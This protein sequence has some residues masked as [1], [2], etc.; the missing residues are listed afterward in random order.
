MSPRENIVDVKP[1]DE[2]VDE[3]AVLI[4]QGRHHAS[5]LDLYRLVEEEDDHDGDDDGESKIARP[6]KDGAERIAL[7]NQFNR[8]RQYFLIHL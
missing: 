2:L 1:V 5:T 7:L 4:G 8:R 3:N 6:I